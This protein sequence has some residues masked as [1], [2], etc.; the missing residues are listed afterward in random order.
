MTFGV[1]DH[2]FQKKKSLF[3]PG[4]LIWVEAGAGLGLGLRLGL[5]LVSKVVF[6]TCFEVSLLIPPEPHV[7]NTIFLSFILDN[8]Q[9]V[10]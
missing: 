7:D 9:F 3:L 5:D 10:R 6:S 4:K 1:V 2:F 8:N